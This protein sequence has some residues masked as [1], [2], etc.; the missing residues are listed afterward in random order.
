MIIGNFFDGDENYDLK[1]MQ[2]EVYKD[3][4]GLMISVCNS[5]SKCAAPPA[6]L[7]LKGGDA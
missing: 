4:I 6:C 3:A 5:F 1:I 2:H 7:A